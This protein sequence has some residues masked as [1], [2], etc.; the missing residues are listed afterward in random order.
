CVVAAEAVPFCTYS[1]SIFRGA[2]LWPPILALIFQLHGLPPPVPIPAA[3]VPFSPPLVADQGVAFRFP[4]SRCFP[5]TGFVLEAWFLAPPPRERRDFGIWVFEAA[6]GLLGFLF[7]LGLVAVSS[8]YTGRRVILVRGFCGELGGS[9]EE[10]EMKRGRDDD[11]VMGPLFPRLHV[12]D[13]DKGGPRAPPRNKMALYE[14]LS[15]PSQRFG[16]G[17][18]PSLP[19]PPHH[20]GGL[21]PSASLNQVCGQ[22]R[23]VFSPFYVPSHMAAHAT[24][25]A[26]SHLA[27]L[28]PNTMRTELEKKSQKPVSQSMVHAAGNEHSGAECSSLR[29]HGIS[30]AKESSKKLGGNDDFRVPTLAQPETTRHPGKSLMNREI[31]THFHTGTLQKNGKIVLKSPTSAQNSDGKSLEQRSTSIFMSQKHERCSGE[32]QAKEADKQIKSTANMPHLAS[33]EKS[34]EPSKLSKSSSNQQCLC[35]KSNELESSYC[36]TANVRRERSD[37]SGGPRQLNDAELVGKQD[38]S[39][40]RSGSVG[41]QDMSNGRSG[42]YSQV[43]VGNNRRGSFVTENGNSLCDDKV[44]AVG[45]GTHGNGSPGNA[46]KVAS[47][48]DAAKDHSSGD[49]ERNDD[50]SETS[51]VDSLSGVGISPDDVVGVIG[52]KHF[53]KARRVIVNQQRVFALQVFELHRLIKVQKLIAESPHLLFDES[54]YLHGSSPKAP[55]KDL[56][57]NS[58][59]KPQQHIDKEKEES[60]DVDKSSEFPK[61]N[62]ADN[63]SLHHEDNSKEPAGQLQRNGF[64]SGN[65]SSAA[66]SDNK[67]WPFHL[68]GNQWLIPVMS[69]TEGLIYKPFTGPC[70]PPGALMAPVYGGCGAPSVLPSAGDFMS[71]AYGVPASHKQQSVGVIPGTSAVA[72]N[73]FPSPIGLPAVNPL[74]SG[75][76]VEQVSSLAGPWA[77]GQKEQHSRSSYNM[78]NP[79]NESFS[80]RARRVQMTRDI[81]L[82]GSTAS[83]PSKRTQEGGRAQPLFPMAFAAER[84]QSHC[85]DQQPRVIKVVPHNRRT[86]TE[87]AARIFQSIQKERQRQ[88]TLSISCSRDSFLFWGMILSGDTY[89][90]GGGI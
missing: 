8:V 2:S 45:E 56:H 52:P 59:V 9:A 50:G 41:K 70:P 31:I 83:S 1:E 90:I 29:P 88:D 78:S 3:A 71:P 86:A 7:E 46:Y 55:V 58:L 77:N 72:P 54:S 40:G 80:E 67:P 22:E 21:V 65:L 89:E 66:V 19:L 20:A 63:P 14:Q 27:G 85:R 37:T 64:C 24:E 74:A 17:G 6:S 32:G 18:A 5:A 39:N 81:D 13:A 25:R 79:K 28:N 4:G 62:M 53:W 43:P 51:M 57:V 35:G 75:T 73:F 15:I 10:E 16:S 44:A 82:Q 47:S 49:A 48:G 11:K 26:H 61:E 42:S 30:S 38:M 34:T 12:N 69:P 84:R 87:S 33:R 76:A 60:V 36:G 23:S 68:P